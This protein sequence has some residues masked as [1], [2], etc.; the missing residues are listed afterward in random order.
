M[1]QIKLNCGITICKILGPQRL[2]GFILPWAIECYIVYV[3]ISESN[4]G[5]L[6]FSF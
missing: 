2:D 4:V 6:L 1:Q 3:L 5:M